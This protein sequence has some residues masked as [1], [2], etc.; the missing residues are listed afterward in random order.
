[1]KYHMTQMK[2]IMRDYLRYSSEIIKFNPASLDDEDENN[3]ENQDLL[4]DLVYRRDNCIDY[5]SQNIESRMFE[6]AEFKA[7]FDDCVSLNLKVEDSLR[8][9]MRFTSGLIEENFKN[10]SNQGRDKI[11]MRN[12][13]K[14][15]ELDGVSNF[16]LDKKK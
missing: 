16:Y 11:A 13:F 12:Y 1:M 14:S 7:M 2:D 15:Q 3:L 10:M 6:D 4:E 8:E 9:M 5:M